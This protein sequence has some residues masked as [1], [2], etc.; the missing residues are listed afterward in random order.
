MSGCEVPGSRSSSY[1]TVSDEIAKQEWS[2]ASCRT[3][4]SACT[5][6]LQHHTP[7]DQDHTEWGG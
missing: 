2:V 6:M 3:G 5:V 1:M 7:I 4:Q